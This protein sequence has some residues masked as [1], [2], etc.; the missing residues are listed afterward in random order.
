MGLVPSLK[1]R[2]VGTDGLAVSFVTV[3]VAGWLAS[4]GISILYTDSQQW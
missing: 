2:E 3:T 4:F 1:W